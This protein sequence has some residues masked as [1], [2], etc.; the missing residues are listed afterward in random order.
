MVNLPK[1]N[2]TKLGP[3][4]KDGA[5]PKLGSIFKKKRANLKLNFEFKVKP[6][7]GSILGK[8]EPNFSLVLIL[9]LS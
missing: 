2:G 4:Y 7:L 8:K 1:K 3:C 5:W 9:E 6:K